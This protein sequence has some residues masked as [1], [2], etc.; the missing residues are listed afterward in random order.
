MSTT[1]DR[2]DTAEQPVPDATIV[3]VHRQRAEPTAC[4]SAGADAPAASSTAG[5]SLD[6]AFVAKLEAALDKGFA[7]SR[8]PE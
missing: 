2:T 3:A 8:M 7:D 1:P 5:S 6:P 4:P